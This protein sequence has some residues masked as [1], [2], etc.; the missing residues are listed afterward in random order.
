[1]LSVVEPIVTK[2]KETPAESAPYI[3]NIMKS[4]LDRLEGL[5]VV[6]EDCRV[7]YEV[8][9]QEKPLPLGEIF[10]EKQ[11]PVGSAAFAYDDPEEYIKG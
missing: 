10:I 7:A 5:A 11:R 4:Y 1:M 9:K 2:F 8:K 3:M 6:L